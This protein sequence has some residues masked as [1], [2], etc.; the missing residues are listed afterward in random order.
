MSCAWDAVQHMCSPG[1]KPA[2]H[3]L[4]HRKART[5]R[6]SC[7]RRSVKRTEFHKKPAVTAC[8]IITRAALHSATHTSRSSYTHHTQPHV[9]GSH[10]GKQASSRH[11]SA[12]CPQLYF[13]VCQQQHPADTRN[14]YVCR[15]GGCA[16]C[17][18]TKQDTIC[19]Y[20]L[21]A[22]SCCQRKLVARQ[23]IS[24]N[25]HLPRTLSDHTQASTSQ[26]TCHWR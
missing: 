1:A 19:T 6:A 20:T 7:S 4:Q 5:A 2:Q 25:K 22:A 10:Q 14:K 23:S 9:R 24:S 8:N 26:G 17:R 21:L 13:I 12:S 11:Y 18:H 16:A 15:P 3:P